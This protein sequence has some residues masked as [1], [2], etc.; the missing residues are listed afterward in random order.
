MST[1]Q[2]IDLENNID[3]NVSPGFSRPLTIEL[4]KE[5][6][7]IFNKMKVNS[8]AIRF[9]YASETAQFANTIAQ[10]LKDNQFNVLINGVIDSDIEK[11]EFSIQRNP[12]D[13]QFAIIKIGVLI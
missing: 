2:K 7:G 5:L 9:E 1:R 6:I 11:N 4:Q 12:I 13:C 8:I 10:F 3:F